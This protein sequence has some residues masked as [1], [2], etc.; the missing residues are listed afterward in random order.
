MS[1]VADLGQTGS[2]PPSAVIN[3]NND[4]SEED[5]VE[6]TVTAPVLDNVP[7]FPGQ[8]LF[9]VT[10]GGYHV[11]PAVADGSQSGLIVGLALNESPGNNAPVTY[12]FAGI[13]E[14][15]EAQ[16]Q[17]VTVG[18]TG[19]VPGAPYYVS[20]SVDRL[21]SVAPTTPG[22]QDILI[23]YAISTTELQLSIQYP[24]TVA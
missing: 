16:W 17:T 13:T 19:L 10:F 7:I 2:R 4:P 18:N 5:L 3:T 6:F 23:G 15:T 9:S 1:N 24:Q 14:L 21:T 8:A 20:D 11:L 22:H 12:Q